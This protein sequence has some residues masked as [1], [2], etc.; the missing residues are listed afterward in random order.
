MHIIKLCVGVSSIEELAEWRAQRRA[1]GL[2]RPDGLNVHRTR[3]MPK[4][5]D[6]II[7][8]GSLYWVISGVIRCRQVIAGLEAATDAEGRTCCNILLEPELIRTTPYPRRPFQGWRYLLPKDAPPDLG[9]PGEETPPEG[10][11]EEL[12]QLGLI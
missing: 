9:R 11:A 3:M 8:Q 4:K 1:Q 10:M 2:G 7:G 5:A 12:A 6:E